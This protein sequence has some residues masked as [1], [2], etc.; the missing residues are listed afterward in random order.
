MKTY[1]YHSKIFNADVQATYNQAGILVGFTVLNGNVVERIDLESGVLKNYAHE[2]SFLENATKNKLKLTEIERV[3]T[4][5][6][7]WNTYKQKDCGRTKAEAIWDKL[8]KAD[9]LG[10]YDFIPAFDGILKL[11]GTAKPYATTYINSKRWIR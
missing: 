9:Q 2:A 6:M 5:E 4:F 11:N 7:F 10:A 8:S 3:V 1:Q